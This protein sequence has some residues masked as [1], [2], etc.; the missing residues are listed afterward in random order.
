MRKFLGCVFLTICCHYA[1]SSRRL[2]GTEYSNEPRYSAQRPQWR[3]KENFLNFYKPE[4]RTSRNIEP[5]HNPSRNNINTKSLNMK[6][7]FHLIF[8]SNSISRDCIY[9]VQCLPLAARQEVLGRE[10]EQSQGS[11]GPAPAGETLGKSH[12]NS[13]AICGWTEKADPG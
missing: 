3:T 9:R 8:F 13:G 10:G 12:F 2:L 11:P 5:G 4:L 6:L 7:I 1:Q